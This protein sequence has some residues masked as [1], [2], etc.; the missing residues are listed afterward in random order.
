[1]AKKIDNLESEISR[2]K[3]IVADATD[4]TNELETLRLKTKEQELQIEQMNLEKEKAL[5]DQ[6]NLYEEKISALVSDYEA[7]IR[8]QKLELG[9]TQNSN[10]KALIELETKLR[11]EINELQTQYGKSINDYEKKVFMLLTEI[12]NLKPKATVKQ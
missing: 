6:K 4:V 11:K 12:E 9:Q 7:T 10:G 1:M 3:T 8:N 5:I 2:Q